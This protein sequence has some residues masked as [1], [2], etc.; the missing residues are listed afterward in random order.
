MLDTLE[1]RATVEDYERL[2]EGA[3][4]QLI[5]GELI[6]TPSPTPFHQSIIYRLILALGNCVKQKRLGVLLQSPIDVHLSDEDVYQPDLIF[7]RADRARGIR[8]DKL[9]VIPDLVVEVLS[10]STGYYD[11]TRKKE[12]YCTS[13]VEEYWIVNPE[14]ETIEIMV[15]RGEIYQTEQLLHKSDTLESAM[16]PGF[17]MKIEDV[18]EF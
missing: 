7:I 2:P 9:R 11:L 3:P 12:M 5:A 16:F 4:Y 8:K 14:A 17:S 15:K 6:M 18:F 1:K 10:P 13:G